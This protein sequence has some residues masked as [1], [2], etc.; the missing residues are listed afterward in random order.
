M[1]L[2]QLS[3]STTKLKECLTKPLLEEIVQKMKL[4]FWGWIKCWSMWCKLF[5]GCR[6]GWILRSA[7]LQCML[8]CEIVSSIKYFCC[9]YWSL[10]HHKALPHSWWQHNGECF[11]MP[12]PL[13]FPHSKHINTNIQ[14][15]RK[16]FQKYPRMVWRVA[17][18]VLC[19]RLPV[20]EQL[21]CGGIKGNGG[22]I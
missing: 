18:Q 15:A 13:L 6:K 8:M 4:L 21:M 20:S 10:G 22:V 7:E 19:G 2:P 5:S 16:Y 1:L 11:V 3:I 12:T 9:E 17:S 14:W